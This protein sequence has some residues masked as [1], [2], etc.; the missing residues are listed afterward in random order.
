[1]P[2]DLASAPELRAVVE[3]LARRFGDSILETAFEKKELSLRIGAGD[4]LTVLEHLKTEQGFNAL[5][6]VIGL[7]HMPAPGSSAKRFSVL[8]QLYR[9]PGAARVRLV[10]D[11][12][13]DE[14]LPSVTPLYASANWAER[15]AFDMFGI[16]FEG[17]PD[18]RRIYLPD[19]FAGYPLRKDFPLEG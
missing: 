5:D 18:L 7:D 10:V 17:H 14:A 3:S 6:D 15:E 12:G 16:R 13:E 4:L 9:F 1:M 2:D 8:Y 19:D 11:V